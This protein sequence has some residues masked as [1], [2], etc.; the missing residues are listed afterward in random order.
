[1]KR[2]AEQD[3]IAWKDRCDRK[4]LVVSG[5]RQVGKTSLIEAF[6]RRCFSSMITVNLAQAREL[7]P[8]FD[9]RQPQQVLVG[10]EQHFRQPL[11]PGATLLFMDGVQEC[12]QALASLDAFATQMPDLH[13]IASGIFHGLAMRKAGLPMPVRCETFHLH[14]LTFAAF[15]AALGE[16]DLVDRLGNMHIGDQLPPDLHE[17]LS[18]WLLIYY[19]VGGMPSVV[20]AYREQRSLA[21]ARQAQMAIVATIKRDFSRYISPEKGRDLRRILNMIPVAVGLGQTYE[22]TVKRAGIAEHPEIRELLEQS[23]FIIPV[24]HCSAIGLPPDTPAKDKRFK[25]L[26]VDIGLCGALSDLNLP[27]Q[28]VGQELLAIGP[29]F[30]RRDLWYWYHKARNCKEEVEYLWPYEGIHIPV[31]SQGGTPRLPSHAHRYLAEDG[32]SVAVRCNLDQPSVQRFTVDS[33][34]AGAEARPFTLLCVPAYLIGQLGRLLGE[35]ELEIFRDS[36]SEPV[37]R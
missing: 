35:M 7:H 25:P 9:D 4:P 8:L 20:A 6:G 31:E 2:Q 37:R 28:F 5:A 34:R 17:R 11:T 23:G 26:I 16:N 3:L 13:V 33:D 32:Y 1:M 12:P 22:S 19:G 14:P 30:I 27:S 36:R 18:D 21:E 24:R 10:L 15:L 29:A